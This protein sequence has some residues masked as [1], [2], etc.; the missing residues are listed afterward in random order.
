MLQQAIQKEQPFKQAGELYRS[1][2]TQEKNDLI[3]NLAA[4][5]GQVKDPETK[6]LM[7]SYFYKADADYGRRLTVATKG[8]LKQ[9][10]AK[11]ALLQD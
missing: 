2:S 5:L 1:Y 4:D 11:A 3:R 8:N 7:L 9:V 6:N 10:E